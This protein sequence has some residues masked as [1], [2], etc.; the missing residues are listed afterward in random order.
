[1]IIHC[2]SWVNESL[3]FKAQDAAHVLNG[4]KPAHHHDAIL[5]ACNMIAPVPTPEMQRMAS[6]LH[7]QLLLIRTAALLK[8]NDLM[9]Q[10]G[11]VTCNTV[12]QG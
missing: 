7:Q 3:E 5:L 8:L 9:H 10:E 12:L 4:C 1:M 2:G 6:H 11:L